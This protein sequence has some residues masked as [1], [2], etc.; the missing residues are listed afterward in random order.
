MP[1]KEKNLF[2]AAQELEKADAYKEAFEFYMEYLKLYPGSEKSDD[3]LLK[4][5]DIALGHAGTTWGHLSLKELVE[6][7]PAGPRAAESIFRLGEYEYEHGE[8]ENAVF[9]LRTL[10][11]EYP[12]SERIEAAIFLSGESE[13]GR[14]RGTDY[15][16][17]PLRESKSY[18]ELLLRRYPLGA[19]AQRSREMLQSIEKELAKRDYLM[20]LYYSR[21][22][23]PQSARF[24]LQCIV[25]DHP[26]SQYAKLAE[27]ILGTTR[28]EER[29][30]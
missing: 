16:F 14:Y 3:I 9:T 13:F 21:H 2:K 22:G 29:P 11:R 8:Y 23:K 25:R 19:Y 18:Y 26:Q 27:E 12:E 28:K 4:I 6:E 10:I 17:A 24:Y 1:T 20:A 15:D 30:E 7:Y 5:Y